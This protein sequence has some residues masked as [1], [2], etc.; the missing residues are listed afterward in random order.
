MK[1]ILSYLSCVTLLFV[2]S[3]SMPVSA[4]NNQ[5][6][7]SKCKELA[8]QKN[9]QGDDR[10]NFMQT[11]V[12]KAEDVQQDKRTACKKLADEKN[13]QGHDRTSFL[14]DCMDKA[15]SR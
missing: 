13:L 6:K 10:K 15:N 4:G 3:G 5:D 8:D 7:V 9:L 2:M 11:C 12:G 1:K 14:K